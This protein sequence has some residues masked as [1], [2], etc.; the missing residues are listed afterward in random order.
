V[1]RVS[2]GLGDNMS[3]DTAQSCLVPPL[4]PPRNLTNGFDAKLFDCGIR[5]VAYASGGGLRDLGLRCAGKRGSVFWRRPDPR[6]Q[7]VEKVLRC[8]DRVEVEVDNNVV[9]V[10]DRSLHTLSHDPGLRP[11]I[12]KALKRCEP[13]IEVEMACSMCNVVTVTSSMN[14]C[15]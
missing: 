1:P 5:V 8:V 10:I 15:R 13:P 4:G 12:C 6:L 7:E 3:Q 11:G 14:D 2:V 9:G